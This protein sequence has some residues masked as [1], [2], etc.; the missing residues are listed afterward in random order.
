MIT[1]VVLSDG[2]ISRNQKKILQGQ[3]SFYQRLY[4]SDTEIEFTFINES[5]VKLPEDEK[6]DIDRPI[7]LKELTVSLKSLRAGQT[8]GADGIPLRGIVLF[9]T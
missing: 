9:G 7:T 1:C 8:L 6:H 3:A 4:S 5:Q 2:S